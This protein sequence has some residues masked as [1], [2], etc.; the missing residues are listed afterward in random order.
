MKSK[1]VYV[2]KDILKFDV[3]IWEQKKCD[4]IRAMISKHVA[5]PFVVNLE[6]AYDT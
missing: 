5:S 3:K 1:K 4:E 6:Y 2:K